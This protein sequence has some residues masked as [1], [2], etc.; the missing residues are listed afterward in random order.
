MLNAYEF[1]NTIG[2]DIFELVGAVGTKCQVLNTAFL[3][4]CFQFCEIVKESAGINTKRRLPRSAGEKMDILGRKRF[5]MELRAI[6][7]SFF[8]DDG[9]HT[10]ETNM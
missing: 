5:Q 1:K 10:V 8:E 9:Q 3:R 4:T 2:I 6:L 7:Q